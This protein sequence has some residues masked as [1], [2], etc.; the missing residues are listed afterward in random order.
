MKKTRPVVELAALVL[1]FL[2]GLKQVF[3]LTLISLRGSPA[4]FTY[5]RYCGMPRRLA[6]RAAPLPYRIILKQRPKAMQ[7][8]ARAAGVDA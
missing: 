8:A 6:R 5:A 7:N 3:H 2:P 4:D 1:F